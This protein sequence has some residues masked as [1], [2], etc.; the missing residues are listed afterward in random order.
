MTSNFLA[1]LASAAWHA[2]GPVCTVF[3]PASGR[4]L[5]LIVDQAAEALGVYG[6]GVEVQHK[7]VVN[8]VVATRA[9]LCASPADVFLQ[10]ISI[11]FDVSMLDIFVP[12]A[13]GASIVPAE[14]GAHR[15]APRLLRQICNS[16]VTIACAVPSEVEMWHAAGMQALPAESSLVRWLSHA[17]S[18]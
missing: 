12:L 5:W 17:A 8:V 9:L 6:Q 10:Q 16:A 7:G 3:M 13:T 4:G 14:P 11:C 2:D 15:D 18:S 1:C